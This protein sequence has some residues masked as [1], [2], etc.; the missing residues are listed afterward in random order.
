MIQIHKSKNIPKKL[1]TKG[2]TETNQLI[3]LYLQDK[4]Y[5]TF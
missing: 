4:D 2:L 3:Q 1:L 5:R